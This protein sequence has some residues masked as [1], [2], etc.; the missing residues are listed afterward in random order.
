MK[1]AVL[2]TLAVTLG[3]GA[4]TVQPPAAKQESLMRAAAPAALN[5]PDSAQ[6]RLPAGAMA[7]SADSA[8]QNG[9]GKL[10][11]KKNPT[12]AMLRSMALPGWGQW[13]NEKKFKAV[14]FGGA[15]I[16]LVADAI[17]QNQLAARSGNILDREFY[18]NNR[19]LAIWYLGAAI[20][21][22][23]ADAYVDAHLFDFDDRQ[24]LT[25]EPA[26]IPAASGADL[27]MALN[28][29]LHF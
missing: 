15:E 18:R 12:S 21:Y 3:A 25:L 27:I 19:S 28:L 4:Q 2:L 7:A 23:M 5:L 16:G 6:S 9:K 10:A 17:V 29:A 26:L 13:Y 1:W 11:V 22:S 8:A 20:L 14:I 24:E